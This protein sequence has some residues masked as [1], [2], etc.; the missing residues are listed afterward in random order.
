MPPPVFSVSVDY[1]SSSHPLGLFPLSTSDP[2]NKQIAAAYE[3]LNDEVLRRQYDLSRPV[4]PTWKPSPTEQGQQNRP[5]TQDTAAERSKKAN[6]YARWRII[7]H[8]NVTDATNLVSKIKQKI[9]ALQEQDK[10][11][12]ERTAQANSWLAYLLGQAMTEDEK[13]SM[14]RKKLDRGASR[15]IETQKLSEAQVRLEEQ[16]RILWNGQKNERDR[17]SKEYAENAAREEQERKAWADRFYKEQQEKLAAETE[18]LRKEQEARVA[19]ENHERQKREELRGQQQERQEEIRRQQQERQEEI[20][21]QE[22]QRQ[23]ETRRRGWRAAAGKAKESNQKWNPGSCTHR[24]YWP[25]TEGRH[26]CESCQR[27]QNLFAMKCPG[28]DMVACVSC[29][30]RLKVEGGSNRNRGQS[31]KSREQRQHEFHDDDDAYSYYD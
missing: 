7:Q 27:T 28:C 6:E 8:S 23:E 19:R 29:M 10:R 30:K 17:L 11:D 25:R 1:G 22:Q 21:R 4:K 14:T 31:S 15:R 26:Q 3:V 18:R 5:P 13:E 20:R 2:Y 12:E 9:Q 24:L 16:Q